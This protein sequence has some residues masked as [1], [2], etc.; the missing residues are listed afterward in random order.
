MA[1][2][3]N[4]MLSPKLTQ[5]CLAFPFDRDGTMIQFIREWWQKQDHATRVLPGYLRKALENFLRTG[6]RQAAALAYYAIFSVFPLTLLLAVVISKLLGP[7]AAQKQVASALSIFL[8]GDT[9]T[10]L[11]QNVSQALEQGTSFTLVAIAGLIWSAL[12]L[13][14]N[15]TSALDTI[16]AVPARRSLWRQRMTA[17]TMTM[18]LVIL[19]TASFVT[20]GV[21]RLVSAVFLERPNPWITIGAVFLPLGLNIV[22]FAL[23]FRY[24]PSRH[25]NWDAVW[26]AAIFG[27]L[28]W[29]LAKSAFQWYLTN[30]ANY[31]FIY[32]SIATAIVLLLW[33]YLIAAIFLISAEFCAQLNDWFIMRQEKEIERLYAESEMPPE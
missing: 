2:F 9:S 19:V 10:L 24:V 17:L 7:A 13:F 22:I 14:S 8:P 3:R 32:G 26:P 30:L 28:G 31:Q 11:Q 18:M 1:M 4:A 6:T 29:E 21:F 20:S 23:L 15:I 16:F 27:G 25:V 12:G 33:A 5:F